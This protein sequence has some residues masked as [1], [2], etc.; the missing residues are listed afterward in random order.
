[1]SESSFSLT[2]FRL[3]GPIHVSETARLPKPTLEYEKG[4]FTYDSPVESTCWIRYMTALADDVQELIKQ[5]PKIVHEF[6]EMF[7][8]VEQGVF[9]GTMDNEALILSNIARESTLGSSPTMV[10]IA[11]VD[12]RSVKRDVE[13]VYTALAACKKL[14]LHTVYAHASAHP[15]YYWQR[16]LCVIAAAW[17]VGMEAVVLKGPTYPKDL[18]NAF[19]DAL[20]PREF[21]YFGSTAYNGKNDWLDI[22]LS[23][24]NMDPR[25]RH[26]PK[27]GDMIRFNESEELRTR[28]FVFGRV[29]SVNEGITFYNEATSKLEKLTWGIKGYFYKRHRVHIEPY[30][31]N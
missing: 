13:R 26:K 31:E 28:K 2:K 23:G 1:M 4:A 10:N 30:L 3:K 27:P 5:P 22:I 9:G 21:I 11:L 7:Y 12:I 20:S 29:E 16:D 24:Y 8:F 25:W 14:G 6:P 15:P 19:K 18:L 17:L